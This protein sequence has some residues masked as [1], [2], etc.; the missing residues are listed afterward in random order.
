MDTIPELDPPF[1]QLLDWHLARGT[2]ADGSPMEKGVP[3][4]NKNFA[5]SVGSKST[6][7]AK[8]ERT[9][10]NWRNGATLPSPAD[11]LAILLGLFG[12]NQDYAQ[13]KAEL[14]DK[15]HTARSQVSDEPVSDPPVPPNASIPTKPPRCMGRDEE[16]NSVVDALAS[17]GS[18]AI[19]VLGGPGMGKTTLTREAANDEAVIQRFGNR[20]WF[21]ELEMA[22]DTQTF[23][24]AIV[25]ALG[26]DPAVAKFDATLAMLRLA[27]GLIV[28]DNLETPWD[29]ARDKIESLL[30]RL[31][32]VPTLAILASIRGNEPPGGLRWT[33]QRTMHPLEWPHDRQLFLDI[34]QDIKANDRHLEQL[35]K[36]LGGIPLAIELIAQ[37][38]AAHD[39][40]AAILDEWRRVGSA[41][42]QRRGGEP[43]RLTSL[44]ISL[45]LSFNSQRLGDAGRRLFC[46]LG[47]LPA[48]IGAESLKALLEDSA[49]DARHGLLSCGLAFEREGR[50]DLLPPVRDHARRFRPPIDPDAALWRNYFLAL[51]SDH[52]DRIDSAEDTGSVQQLAAELPNLATAQSAAISDGDLEAALAALRGIAV[53]IQFTGLGSS[54]TIHELSI[55]CRAAGNTVGLA[56][57]IRFIGSIALERSDHAAARKAYEQA[58]PLYRQVDDTLGEADCILGLGSIARERSDHEAAR[59]AYD[60]ALPLYRQAGNILG[61]A[62][63]IMNLGSAAR[64]RSDYKAACKAYEQALLLFRQ[65]GGGIVGQAN[66]ILGLGDV[67]FAR[68]DYAAARKA[69]EQALSLYRQVGNILGEANCIKSLGDIALARSDQ[70]AARTKFLEALRLYERIP[71]PYSVGHTHRRLAKMARGKARQGHIAAARAAWVSINRTDLVSLLD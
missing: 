8:S 54:S 13:W 20:R 35:L 23:E 34:A 51:A 7:G 67:A 65:A 39:T 48:G 68:A 4:D 70:D 26:L 56:D 16:V 44:D 50:L 53:V 21:V 49:F 64:A 24:A 1:G 10:R 18:A 19:L 71:E 25:K 37:Q 62:I 12:G 63:C 55:A 27:P 60:Q 2:R 22:T 46:I 29:G 6:E 38:A 14:T 43:S 32:G 52:G 57:C 61:E 28:L 15:Y 47:Q 41:L 40:V 58:L 36:E 31:S 45:E 59:K 42:A 30:D 17:P 66:C 11:F 5:K 3:W 69:Y 33:R 9:I